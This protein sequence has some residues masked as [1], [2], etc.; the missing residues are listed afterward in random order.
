[1]AAIRWLACEIGAGMF[2]EE[3]AVTIT[4][5]QGRS[6]DAF[7]PASEVE[8][9][10]G[11]THGRVRVRPGAPFSKLGQIQGQARPSPGA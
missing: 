1:M 6:I 3:R 11:T 10:A 7:V 2:S 9:D 8:A 4:L 5:P